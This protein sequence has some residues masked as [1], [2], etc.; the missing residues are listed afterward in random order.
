VALYSPHGTAFELDVAGRTPGAVFS[1][2]CVSSSEKRRKNMEIKEMAK[3]VQE[4]TEKHLMGEEACVTVIGN[5]IV[6]CTKN[7]PAYFL[8]GVRFDIDTPK[9]ILATAANM[10]NRMVFNLSPIETTA[11]VASTMPRTKHIKPR[12]GRQQQLQAHS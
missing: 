5:D 3:L 6:L 11:I 10:I 12:C 7:R 4:F 8:T 1:I 9:I 2:V